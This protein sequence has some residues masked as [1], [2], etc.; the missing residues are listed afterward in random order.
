MGQEGGAVVFVGGIPAGA[1]LFREV[2]KRLEPRK[3]VALEVV[4]SLFEPGGDPV[5]RLR[6]AL[7]S[8]EPALVVAHG[9][10]VP[11]VMA[12]LNESTVPVVV[13]N[14]PIRRV[15]WLFRAL[16]SLPQ[17]VLARALFR[18]AVLN[19]WLSSSLGL[20]RA[21]VNPYVM[22]GEVVEFLTRSMVGS[23]AARQAAASWIKMLSGWLPSSRS[24]G[25]WAIWG[26]ADWLYPADDVLELL[27]K[28]RVTLI[29]GGRWFHPEERPWCWQMFVRICCLNLRSDRNVARKTGNHDFNVVVWGFGCGLLGL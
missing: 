8:L 6:E 28:D 22:E 24:E 27:G 21:V 9:V 18:P 2:Q 29:P 11:L 17:G 20:R 19:A 12:A 7:G 5:D 13:S 15:D 26:D 3:T 1:G 23:A 16:S 25:V 10:A 4:D 14:G